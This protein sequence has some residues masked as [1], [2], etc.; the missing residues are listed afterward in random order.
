MSYDQATKTYSNG[1]V[2]PGAYLVLVTGSEVAVYNPMVV[3][4]YYTKDS[5]H[6]EVLNLEDGYATAKKGG[7]PDVSKKVDGTDGNS[8]EIGDDVRYEVTIDPVPYYG[9]EYPVLNIVDTLSNGLTYNNGSLSVKIAGETAPLSTE[10]YDLRVDNQIITVDF[11]KDGKGYTL[12]EF[13][14]KALVISYTAKINNSAVLNEKPNVNEVTLNYT[15]DSKVRGADDTDDDETYT[16]T[17][18]I[19]GQ[20]TGTTGIID[21]VGDKTNDT[22]GLD[23]AVFRL[24]KENPDENPDAEYFKETTT[25]T[26]GGK[27]GQMTF[28]GLEAG[29][30]YYLKEFSAPGDY[31]LNT[32][33]YTIVINATY[34]TQDDSVTKENY[35]KLKTWSVLIDGVSVANF[36]INSDGTTKTSNITG[37]DI[38]NTTMSSLPSTGGIGTTIFTIGGCA[39]MIAAAGLFFASR[40]KQENK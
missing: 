9:G 27:A 10:Y 19:D 2:A 20:R 30:P 3:S 4:V 25:T 36:E 14:G 5:L 33:V 32:K 16:Y 13:K 17:F 37:I 28:T 24:Y 18:E 34:Y 31:T 6:E 22:Q 1:A 35:G 15:K 26:V 40:R 7:F 11:V 23:G 21:K 8:A 39:I 38:Q 12:N 29:T